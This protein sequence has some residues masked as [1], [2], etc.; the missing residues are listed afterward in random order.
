MITNPTTGNLIKDRKRKTPP[1]REED[2][3]DEICEMAR[4]PQKPRK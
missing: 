4:T 1:P 3:V 2:G